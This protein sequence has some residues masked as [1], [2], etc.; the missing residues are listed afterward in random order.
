MVKNRRLCS[1]EKR[2]KKVNK[3]EQIFDIFC[4]SVVF[5]LTLLVLYP[6]IYVVSCSFSAP[7]AVSSGRVWLFPVD[8]SLAS[9]RAILKYDAIWSGYKNTIIYTVVGTMIN[10]AMTMVCAYPL[11][12]KNLYGRKTIMLLF[13]F[14][15]LFSSGMIPGYILI[16]KLH[17]IDTIWALVLPGAMSVYNMIVAR[18]FIENNISN[19]LLEAAKID[20]CN[21][22]YYFFKMVLPLSK[23]IIAVLALWYAVGHWNA[24]F[25]AFLYLNDSSK[26]PLQIILREILV[27]NE[28]SGEV[29]DLELEAQMQALKTL[30]KYAVIVVSSAPLM[31]F[32]PFAQKYFVKGVM[33]GSVKG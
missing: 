16:T 17:M 3:K 1:K 18:T 9:Y 22:F 11:S 24:Y 20:G 7:E 32:Y 27:N 23:T 2:R 13:T 6:V 21:D 26:Y 5:V 8:F 28:V 19:E 4:N 30:L 15:M 25:G 33:I 31:F 29:L 12:R 10:I 14:T